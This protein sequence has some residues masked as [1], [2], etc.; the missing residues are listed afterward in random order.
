MPRYN[1]TIR[2]I[3]NLLDASEQAEALIAYYDDVLAE[4]R[5]KVA[6]I[7]EENR[8]RAY[9]A[10]GINGLTTDPKGSHFY[11]YNISD[12]ELATLLAD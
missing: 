10:E 7:P 6:L 12:E 11:H 9:Y 3:G 1:D 2:F 4:V 5:E 8:I